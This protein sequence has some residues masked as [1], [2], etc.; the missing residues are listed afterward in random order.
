MRTIYKYQV[1]PGSYTM[2]PKD[3]VI[4]S[5]G[6]QG[7]N[8]VVWALVDDDMPRV[9]RLVRVHPTG[10]LVLHSAPFIGTVQMADGLVF[11]LF[12]Q[13][14]EKSCTSDIAAEVIKWSLCDI[15]VCVPAEFTDEQ[16]EAFANDDH[17]TGIDSK[18]K[19]RQTKDPMRVQCQ[20]RSGHVHVVLSC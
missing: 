20:E 5:V 17:P 8:I 19:M 9:P 18:W 14:E 11:H 7:L 4:L 16:I 1:L 6:A 12:D 2:M 13:G 10:D 3:A 15:Q